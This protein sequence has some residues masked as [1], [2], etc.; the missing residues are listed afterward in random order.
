MPILQKTNGKLILVGN[1]QTVRNTLLRSFLVNELGFSVDEPSNQYFF[2]KQIDADLIEKIVEFFREIDL[3]IELDSKCSDLY[4]E[5][6]KRRTNFESLAQEGKDIKNR[7]ITKLTIPLMKLPAALKEYQM[8]PVIHAVEMGNVANFSVPGSGKTWMAY[9]AYFLL[10]NRGEVEKLLVVGPLSSF[11]PWENEFREITG[12]KPNSIRISGSPDKRIDIFNHAHLYEMFLVSYDTIRIEQAAVAELLQKYKFMF[13]VD[14]SHHIKNPNG[15][16]TNAIL[17]LSRFAKRRMVLSGTPIPNKL[18]DIWAQFSFLYPRGELL[19]TFGDF[20]YELTKENP[21]SYLRNVLDPFYTR[22]SKNMLDLPKASF[23]RVTVP[24]SKIQRRIYDAI[25]GFI[26]ENDSNYRDDF[27]AVQ[28]WRNNCIV[29][30]IETATDPSLLTKNSQYH[31]QNITNEGLP[32]QQLI[33]QYERFE[34]PRKLEAVRKLVVQSLS[35]KEKTIIWCSFVPTIKKLTNMFKAHKPIPIWGGVPKDDEEDV[36]Y[37]REREIERF[38]SSP[39]HN[40]LIANPASLAESISLHKVC[41]HAIYLDRTFNGGHYMQSLERI[42][43]I[44]MS[45]KTKTRY[46]ILLSKD[47][48]DQVIDDRLEVKKDRML[49]FLNEED[50]G[51]LSLDLDYDNLYGQEDEMEE[52]HRRVFEHIM[53]G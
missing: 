44:G 10:K 30:L 4:Q 43:R 3:S 51:K 17:Y 22:V 25:K 23:I 49:A 24:M 11:R 29:Y 13:I 21:L 50:F 39:K 32:I 31:E 34:I 26:R 2:D 38:R 42:H 7:T 40:L 48:V 5:N 37:N 47:S 33:E 19:G 1:S 14:E 8:L 36:N 52:D 15:E 45:Q 18:E 20:Q 46:T 12:K 6:I 35:K 28:R 27:L 53:K 41:H 16:S 9:F